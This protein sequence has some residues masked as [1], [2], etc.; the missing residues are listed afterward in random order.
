MLGDSSERLPYAYWSPLFLATERSLVNRSGILNFFHSHLRRAVERRYIKDGQ[1]ERSLRLKIADYFEGLMPG[2]GDVSRKADE[3]PWHLMKTEQWPRLKNCI[4]DL[5]LFEYL[6]ESNEYD[7]LH[8]W[9]S[10]GN[11]Y[12]ML[13][14]YLEVIDI[15][16]DRRRADADESWL[17][18]GL[19]SLSN[20][21]RAVGDFIGIVARR[22]GAEQLFKRALAIKKELDDQAHARI[23][24]T[25]GI[26]PE[27]LGRSSISEADTLKSLTNLAMT[28]HYQGDNSEAE[29]LLREV[30]DIDERLYGPE[31]SNTA[32]TMNN[33]AVV[34][35]AKGSLEEAERLCLRALKINEKE[36]GPEHRET[37]GVIHNLGLTLSGLGRHR[38]AAERLGHA[39]EITEGELGTEH[40][41][42][43]KTRFQLAECL[44]RLRDYQEAERLAQ[45]ALQ[46]LERFLSLDHPDTLLSLRLLAR[47]YGRSEAVDKA[48]ESYRRLVEID[49]RIN[50]QD[51]PDTMRDLHELGLVLERKG[52]YEAAE[53]VLKQVLRISETLLG[54]EHLDT[55]IHLA[56]LAQLYVEK[57]DFKQAEFYCR[58]ALVIR[59]KV[60]GTLHADTATSV[61][62]LAAILESVGE[63]Q[64]AEAL[65]LRALDIRKKSLGADDSATLFSVRNLA[66]FYIGAERFDE[67]EHLLR[68]LL[69]THQRLHGLEHKGTAEAMN[70]LGELLFRRGAVEETPA[71][72]RCALDICARTVGRDDPL[73]ARVSQNLETARAATDQ[74]ANR[75]FQDAA[76]DKMEDLFRKILHHDEAVLGA[77]HAD[78]GRAL[79]NLAMV[80]REEKRHDEAQK[81]L[82]RAL[83]I[84]AIHFGPQ[85][86]LT[87]RVRHSLKDLIGSEPHLSNLTSH[88]YS[89]N[90][91]NEK[92]T[93]FFL[94]FLRPENTREIGLPAEAI[95]G[96][97]IGAHEELN[98]SHF[99]PNGA[100][101]VFL[102]RV[103]GENARNCPWLRYQAIKIQNGKIPIVDQRMPSRD[104][105]VA[106]EDIIGEC[107]ARDGVLVGY[108]WSESHRL[109]SD[110]GLMQLDP[111]FEA[112][113][114]KELQ[115]LLRPS[116][117]FGD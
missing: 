85:D 94:S 2:D 111:W 97:F 99:H 1:Q 66:G 117:R 41:D 115:R 63:L 53:S 26:S 112:R 48:E 98:P 68:Q 107:E 92:T 7:L 27:E 54:P 51:H 15:E 4:S 37:A 43:A 32:A 79:F 38:E 28:R 22:G 82:Y 16:E 113:L 96:E 110:N 102:Q 24:P 23:A 39:L 90:L 75:L 25:F 19:M 59:E 114:E 67:A 89:V 77:D 46:I 8:Y 57:E 20:T 40:I 93:R 10:L 88:I 81:L 50:G 76:V 9:H 47:I 33:L 91:S 101:V 36:Q 71:L 74:L 106:L 64:T 65:Y 62:D 18:P 80:L 100:F 72:F 52:D 73:V 104:T 42:T 83:P 13:Q 12:D 17:N 70:D 103:I 11:R 44:Y 58:R 60:L 21:V 45:R 29:R 35:R 30:L 78:T 109:I 6:C 31:S 49:E 3:L 116:N 105:A 108:E 95:V 56:N 14:T 55:V 69:G 84:F 61:N 34:L 87:L 86:A 5:K